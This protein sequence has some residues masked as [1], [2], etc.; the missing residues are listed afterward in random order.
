MLFTGVTYKTSWGDSKTK[1]VNATSES[2]L[3]Q[4][5]GR[6][7]SVILRRPQKFDPYSTDNFTLLSNVKKME[8]IFVAS[9]E[10]LNLQLS[11]KF[12]FCCINIK[13]GFVSS[14]YFAQDCI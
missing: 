3:A 6:Q 8:D 12:Y 10:H 1:N 7:S 9:S 14:T 13:L 11:L 2:I 4:P 5:I